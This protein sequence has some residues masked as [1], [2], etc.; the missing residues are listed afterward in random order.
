[1][2]SPLAALRE[3]AGIQLQIVATGMHLDASRGKSIE[4]LRE[5][6]FGIDRIVPWPAG[7]S[8]SQTRTAVFAGRAMAGLAEAFESLESDIVLVV[9]DRVE[10]FA[11][12]A[13]A[14][15]G[16]RIVAHVHG[17]DRALGLV[18]DSLRH[19]IT[20]LAH[21]HFPATAQSERRI[22]RLGEDAWRVHRAG[23]PGLDGVLRE[24]TAW[25]ELRTKFPTI[26]RRRF[27]LVALHPATADAA[28]ERRAADLVLQ[29]TRSAGFDHLIVIYPNNDPGSAGIVAAWERAPA[30]REAGGADEP[31]ITLCRDLPR[32]LF[33]GLLREAAVLVGNSSAG[34]IEAA[35][36]GTPVVDVGPRQ[37]G[38]ERGGNVRHVPVGRSAIRAAL[39]RAWDGGRAPRSDAVNVYGGGRAGTRIAQVLSRIDVDRHRRKIIGY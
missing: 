35:S 22:R 11:A 17:G 5:A 39:T 15:I 20:K 25:S 30:S 27:A 19:A 6:G 23:S 8:R 13:A 24:A 10:A 4:V 37:W 1:M 29:A 32:S 18:D 26:R 36:F 16:G 12:A 9:G 38:R 28:S 34:I 14:H 2:R 31:P 3:L 7:G 33:L 21:V